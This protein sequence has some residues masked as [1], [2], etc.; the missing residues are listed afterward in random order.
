MNIQTRFLL[1]LEENANVTSA[2]E[3]YRSCDKTEHFSQTFLR[4]YWIKRN[5]VQRNCADIIQTFLFLV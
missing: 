3:L 5:L 1:L 2:G 4:P